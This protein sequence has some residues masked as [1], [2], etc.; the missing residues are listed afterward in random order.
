[1]V[2]N[3]SDK[4]KLFRVLHDTRCVFISND[5]KFYHLN[6]VDIRCF[7]GTLLSSWENGNKQY[8]QKFK[9]GKQ[10]GISLSWWS[11]D[12]RWFRE[13]YK[14]GLKHGKRIIYIGNFGIY[15]CV[16]YWKNGKKIKG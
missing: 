3:F 10:H 1:M 6:N 2:K 12:C 11:N 16:D 14:N 13:Y 8:I 7:T 5:G 15:P 4:V 9:N